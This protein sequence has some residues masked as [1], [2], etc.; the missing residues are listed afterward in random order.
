MISLFYAFSDDGG[1]TFTNHEIDDVAIDTTLLQQPD[2][3]GDYIRIT[4]TDGAAVV[5]YNATGPL[6]P[7]PFVLLWCEQIHSA[8]IVWE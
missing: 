3:I 4:M 8:R 5:V 2:F 6:P 7:S 1:Q